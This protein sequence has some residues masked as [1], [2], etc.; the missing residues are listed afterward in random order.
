MCFSKWFFG[1]LVLSFISSQTFAATGS[2]EV[3]EAAG[4]WDY[5]VPIE[6]PAYR[7]VE[8]HLALHYNSSSPNGILGM[9]WSLTG[10]SEITRSSPDF[11]V[12]KETFYLDGQ[13]LV[14][15]SQGTACK[16]GGNYA[17][18]I[19]SYLRISLH[20]VSYAG[21]GLLVPKFRGKQWTIWRQD[22]TKLT[23]GSAQ[24]NADGITVR[25][26]LT[27]VVDTFGNKAT[28]TWDCPPDD[29][30]G[31]CYPVS[32]TA[33]SVNVLLVYNQ[34]RRDAI[35]YQN[36][37]RVD[38][39]RRVLGVIDVRVAG[40]SV[41][42]YGLDYT[43]S[44][45][46]ARVLLRS[47]TE[48]GSDAF[49]GHPGNSPV[50]RVSNT[51]HL[52]PLTFT[53]N[54]PTSKGWIAN[55]AYASPASFVDPSASDGDSGL[56]LMSLNGSGVPELV[57]T[58]NGTKNM[59]PRV[60][61]IQNSKWIADATWDPNAIEPKSFPPFLGRMPIFGPGKPTYVD[62][63]G[64]GLTDIYFISR[65][66]PRGTAWLNTANGDFVQDDT[67]VPAYFLQDKYCVFVDITGDRRADAICP[68]GVAWLN[69][70]DGTHARWERGKIPYFPVVKEIHFAD[71]DGNG[72]VD[73]LRGSSAVGYQYRDAFINIGGKFV[74]APTYAPPEEFERITEEYIEPIT[75]KRTPAKIYD[76][77]FRLI[78]LNG[79]ALSDLFQSRR[80]AYY[81]DFTTVYRRAWINNGKG[82][83]R[84][85]SWAASA[86][87]LMDQS[88]KGFD[89]G[90]RIADLDG[91]G[92]ADFLG[93]TSFLSERGFPDIMIQVSNGLGG[94]WSI[95]YASSVSWPYSQIQKIVPTVISVTAEDGAGNSS[96]TSYEYSGGLYDG[97]G[98]RFLGFAQVK[99]TLPCATLTCPYIVTN[100]AQDYGTATKP[101]SYYEYDKDGAWPLRM[102]VFS[103]T[104]NG[105][106]IPY[107]SVPASETHYTFSSGVVV[108]QV[109]RAFDDD[110]N[111]I[112]EIN[113]GDT[114]VIGDEVTT[115][116]YYNKNSDAYIVGL[117]SR[118]VQYA[119]TDFSG[120]RLTETRNYYDAADSI[121]TP[122]THGLLTKRLRWLDVH[123]SYV[124]TT[125]AY[126]SLGQ[127]QKIWDENLNLTE[128]VRTDGEHVS[129]IRDPLYVSDPRH[130]KN[131]DWDP[132]CNAPKTMTD[133][134]GGV[135]S[136]SYDKLCRLVATT[137]PSG[138]FVNTSFSFYSGLHQVRNESASADGTSNQW[139]ITYYDGFSRQ[140]KEERKG[141]DGQTI[142][143]QAQYDQAGRLQRQTQPYYRNA[144]SQWTS[145]A[146]DG[147]NRPTQLTHADGSKVS[148]VYGLLSTTTTNERGEIRKQYTDALGR[149]TDVLELV[150]GKLRGLSHEYDALGR[151][152]QTTDDD[153]NVWRYQYDSLGR[154]R[155]IDDPDLG[156]WDF[157]YGAAGELLLQVDAKNQLTSFTYDALGRLQ[158]QVSAFGSKNEARKYWNYDEARAGFA[159][160]GA[161]TTERYG[162]GNTQYNYNFAGDLAAVEYQLDGN[163]YAFAYQYDLGGRLKSARYPD[164][165]VITASYDGAGRLQ[166]VPGIFSSITYTAAGQ[167]LHRMNGNGTDVTATYSAARG[168]PLSV[169]A[170]ASS[171]SVVHDL[172]LSFLASGLP[173]TITSSTPELNRSYAYDEIG[174]LITGKGQNLS[175]TFKYSNTGNLSIEPSVVHAAPGSPRPHATTADNTSTYAY[176][177]NGNMTSGRGRSIVWDADNMPVQINDSTYAYDNEG[178]R[179]KKVEEGVATYY[180]GDD[181]EVTNGVFTKYF[182]LGGQT[183]AKRKGS[184]TSWL[185]VDH[186]GSVQ[187]V[188]DAQGHVSRQSF[189]SYGAPL[190][191]M[192][193]SVGFTGQRHDKMGL[194]YLHAR[195][196]DPEMGQFISPD[197]I[198]PTESPIGL[199]RYAYG[200]SAPT[201]YVD[202]NGHSFWDVL[203]NICTLGMGESGGGGG[204][205]GGDPSY[206]SARSYE[207]PS[208]C[209]NGCEQ[210][211]KPPR[212][213]SGGD[214]SQSSANADST[215]QRP[216][217]PPPPNVPWARSFMESSNGGPGSAGNQFLINQLNMVTDF[218]RDLLDIALWIDGGFALKAGFTAIL[219]A[220]PMVG[221]IFKRAVLTGIERR[222]VEQAEKVGIKEAV[223]ASSAGRMQQ[224]VRRGLAPRDITRVDRPHV[225]G[226]EPHVHFCDGTAC[227]QSGKIHD[228]HRGTPNPSRKAR[229]WLRKHGWESP[230]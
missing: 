62:L 207:P 41:R 140:I 131:V 90:I 116:I 184:Q 179:V 64:D 199:N 65:Y 48:Y 76:N 26:G 201:L 197:T 88:V 182:S 167:M 118:I 35:S 25:W 104:S 79:D 219:K 188:E 80:G 57:A 47:V 124:G 203:L 111:L 97:I 105:G 70:A 196:Y 206:Y 23:Y 54:Q 74:S 21:R 4:S 7:G 160:V 95:A 194:I 119:G 43:S 42:V 213:A 84:D 211:P 117:P 225:G 158:M 192:V 218:Y 30:V 72:L 168:W 39:L 180:L 100:Y 28:Y 175:E 27:E 33:G 10:F 8:P 138:E 174:R 99:K 212:R 103:Y 38:V 156:V 53:Y 164:G 112:S 123:D 178:E 20:D 1:V 121:S 163:R 171:G 120:V 60:W 204:Y 217:T 61:K 195:Y 5:S 113:D 134:N 143:E 176:D 67:Y 16:T 101:L 145:Y 14:A 15:C 56:R 75:M 230:Q 37:G 108:T 229:E 162:I 191:A 24:K 17:T 66:Y 157:S 12:G 216:V 135:T 127:L 202:P 136:Y 144:I 220:G 198:V 59:A 106:E 177:A 110:G 147:L 169:R 29:G 186:L 129:E 107:R 185:Y 36:C 189:A 139:G 181:V 149:V 68:W 94:K 228:A 166:S 161:L 137:L 209:I 109:R 148:L 6:V 58:G 87:F 81:Y 96:V 34:D 50:V 83:T 85:D 73:L 133:E 222:V 190:G 32:V 49:Y 98:Q 78:D 13:K 114:G 142:V 165:D 45:A 155:Q 91:N 152:V 226:Q 51:P 3:L 9:G 146:Y 93:G 55:K 159:N 151:R 69:V 89:T 130:K 173:Q 22:G 71:L 46:T 205:I 44:L 200:N 187:A 86:P 82:W 224:E 154:L 150:G 63:N 193:D 221:A 31:R 208:Y 126:D 153:G 227:T 215:Y 214:S 223:E 183:L 122:P 125:M 132:V 128:F 2:G 141:A 19:E 18:E 170:V 115:A 210:R 172:S 77:G 11:L 52:P 92:S 40:K 102:T